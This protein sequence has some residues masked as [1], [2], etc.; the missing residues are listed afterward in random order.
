MNNAHYATLPCSSR[1]LAALYSTSLEARRAAA[2]VVVMQRL[3]CLCLAPRPALRCD[4]IPTCG[5][6]HGRRLSHREPDQR[7][8]PWMMYGTVLHAIVV[9][10]AIG[11]AHLA[12]CVTVAR[13]LVLLC[14]FT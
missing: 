6:M 4:V 3:A 13:R 10:A 2:A 11:P 1:V 5:S 8:P 12:R 9:F 14:A 7:R